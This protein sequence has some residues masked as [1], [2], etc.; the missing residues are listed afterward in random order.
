MTGMGDT[1]TNQTGFEDLDLRGQVTHPS[2]G[3]KVD[4]LS[5]WLALG[6][7]ALVA[8]LLLSGRGESGEDS[9][10]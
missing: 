9:E 1:T 5:N 6:G 2:V 7:L 10:E 3:Y 4:V 8:F